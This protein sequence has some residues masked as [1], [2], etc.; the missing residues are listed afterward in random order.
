MRTGD[1]LR[2]P[3]PK[4]W[5]GKLSI[6]QIAGLMLYSRHQFVPGMSNFYFGKVTYDG[7][8]LP[9]STA[10]FSALSDQQI[11]FMK[12]DYLRHVLVVTVAS[13]KD[14]AMW[15]NN[16]QE[17]AEGEPWGIPVSISSDPRHGTSVTFE[18]DAGAGGD[19]SHSAGNNREWRLPLTRILSVGLARSLRMSIVPWES[20]PH[21]P[22]RQ[23]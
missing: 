2:K 22:R 1:C 16:L 12:E 19:I 6:E 4:T 15:N 17:L 13:P 9:E 23:I 3:V 10:P 7:K 11:Q 21:F 14:V 18:F 5:P 20:Q 8:E